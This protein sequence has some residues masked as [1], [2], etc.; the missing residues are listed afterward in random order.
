NATHHCPVESKEIA[1]SI[2]TCRNYEW[3]AHI[4]DIFDHPELSDDARDAALDELGYTARLARRLLVDGQGTIDPTIPFSF[5]PKRIHGLIY[6][7]TD[8][9]TDP[10]LRLLMA[11][12]VA[13]KSEC[14]GVDPLE[15]A[16][17]AGKI[18]PEDAREKYDQKKADYWSDR[19]IKNVLNVF[20]ETSQVKA[21]ICIRCGDFK[22]RPNDD[23][24]SKFTKHSPCTPKLT[25]L[26]PL[27]E[28]FFTTHLEVVIGSRLSQRRFCPGSRR[29][30][31]VYP[32]L[33]TNAPGD[34]M[35]DEARWLK[36]HRILLTSPPV[37]HAIP[38]PVFQV[39]ID[40][41]TSNDPANARRI[42]DAET[43]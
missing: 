10:H 38:V 5:E 43:K 23:S 40:T 8:G 29:D 15:V 14:R 39:D 19:F 18:I 13:L 4:H 11:W 3:I 16:E 30:K 27:Q 26:I 2:T 28:C 36:G 20:E 35:N 9:S 21:V 25:S 42:K 41:D 12:D 7:K 37:T 6:Y 31:C 24:W 34:L 17:N 22:I 32:T 1:I 33:A